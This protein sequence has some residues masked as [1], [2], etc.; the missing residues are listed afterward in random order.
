MEERADKAATDGYD[1]Q[2]DIDDL[3][4][5][6]N[7][8]FDAVID[9]IENLSP[10]SQG[11]LD[12]FS[13]VADSKKTFTDEFKES[14]DDIVFSNGNTTK[15][16]VTKSLNEYL[17]SVKE[18]NA[19]NPFTIAF[20]GV[21]DI[22]SIDAEDGIWFARIIQ[23]GNQTD[24]GN[25]FDDLKDLLKTPIMGSNTPGNI[26]K[27]TDDDMD[28]LRSMLAD[29]TLVGYADAYVA[30]Y[31]VAEESSISLDPLTITKDTAKTA[32]YV[33]TSDFRALVEAAERDQTY[34]DLRQELEAIQDEIDKLM[35]VADLFPDLI[36]SGIQPDILGPFD[37]LYDNDR[38]MSE[39]TDYHEMIVMIFD[40]QIAP[41][42]KVYDAVTDLADFIQ[43]KDYSQL[44][45]VA[46]VNGYFE[47][48][49]DRFTLLNTALKE[50]RSSGVIGTQIDD[51]LSD[52]KEYIVTAAKAVEN[53]IKPVLKDL[54][55]A[56]IDNTALQGFVKE[57]L[58]EIRQTVL[59]PLAYDMLD[60]LP[61]L[62]ADE[63]FEYLDLLDDVLKDIDL[64]KSLDQ[65]L[66]DLGTLA[67][68]L[69]AVGS[70]FADDLAAL[71]DE[72]IADFES[73]RDL[74]DAAYDLG[75]YVVGY[76]Y[77]GADDIGDIG[78]YIAGLSDR[79]DA[80][81]S[82]LQKLD[83]NSIS[84]GSEEIVKWIIDKTGS[85][86]QILVPIIGTAALTAAVGF[87]ADSGDPELDDMYEAELIKAAKRA[88]VDIE[89][90]LNGWTDDPTLGDIQRRSEMV[91]DAIEAIS[92]DLDIRAVVFTDNGDVVHRGV[93]TAGNKVTMPYVSN[94]SDKQFVGWYEGT[95]DNL[96][97]KAGDAAL[98]FDDLDSDAVTQLVS[99]YDD[100]FTVKFGSSEFTGVSGT[101]IIV[102]AGPAMADKVFLHWSDGSVQY[103][104]GAEYTIT[105]DAEFTAIYDDVIDVYTVTFKYADATVWTVSVQAGSSIVL[106][107]GHESGKTFI[108]WYDATDN[109]VG[110]R[111][112]S[113]IPTG[114]ITLTAHFATEYTVTVKYLG[115]QY[116]VI[117]RDGDTF[118]LPAF[119][120][121]DGYTFD[122]WSFDGDDAVDTRLSVTP[123]ND[124]EVE[125][126]GTLNVY[127]VQYI[128]GTGGVITQ[129]TEYLRAGEYGLLV[130][131]PDAGHSAHIKEVTN[132]TCTEIAANVYL[133]TATGDGA[134][135]TVEFRHILTS[136]PH[137]SVA[138]EYV[139]DNGKKG[140]E[141]T[142]SS[143]SG[144]F[145]PDS[146]RNGKLTILYTTSW[147]VVSGGVSEIWT[148]TNSVSESI[149][150][151]ETSHTFT[152]W[153]G[154]DAT[155]DYHDSVLKTLVSGSAAFS[156]DNGT[157]GG[158]VTNSQRVI[159]GA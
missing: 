55:E 106:I 147:V 136:H 52:Y 44:V 103:T 38:P 61:E 89:A 101:K 108:G 63:L 96:V 9:Y 151:G 28:N 83:G 67:T 79:Y 73:I 119:T 58:K 118:V 59:V 42:V 132:A 1:W 141:A 117:V 37:T 12:A 8:Y 90:A 142:V 3:E 133:V 80:F 120:T 137:I 131:T 122:G 149:G 138:I 125:W 46:S 85:G 75:S 99:K 43:N 68:N 159:S 94:T 24:L 139:E 95:P 129:K 51:L 109:K 69:G 27:I 78:Q 124:M 121:P 20:G 7:A 13:D 140:F 146:V 153:L 16:N 25:D 98:A 18:G 123:T 113:Y 33:A 77:G 10:P 144:G 30:A 74:L 143:S 127:S 49:S 154:D 71:I 62:T 6:Y 34:Q 48:L 102:P 88:I 115:Y 128:S 35:T 155:N 5:K 130:V 76:D 26:L 134:V 97:W 23:S 126:K 81:N 39:L 66:A 87:D 15:T 29:P 36:P 111:G 40:A 104:A 82:E 32:A 92:N 31:Q 105:A 56:N 148:D 110:V 22:N 91:A 64:N 156:Y 70:T 145:I 41:V 157:P 116:T 17:R 2:S 19:F 50:L 100:I 114:D 54:I 45:D 107:N 65:M 112:E 14:F 152:V 158:A 47:E 57:L 150:S 60:L 93:Y 86:L 21:G 11:T 135:I 4:A 84:P 53:L 72:K